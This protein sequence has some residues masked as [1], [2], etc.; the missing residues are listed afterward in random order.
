MPYEEKAH[1]ADWS[2]HVWAADLPSLLAEAAQGMNMLS[3]AQ[4]AQGPRLKRDFSASGPDAE[5]L[6]V[7]FLTELVYYA[8]NEH[9]VFDQF[10]IKVED[11]R[12]EVEMVGAPLA[13][14]DKSIKAVTYHNLK[15]RQSERGLE[16]EIVFDV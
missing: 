13:A 9:L 11:N 10:E 16:V 3:G 1:T 14:I 2:L 5:S 4:P 8:E 7:T 6:L 12:L 15:I